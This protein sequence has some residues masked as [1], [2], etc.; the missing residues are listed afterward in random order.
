MKNNL[1]KKNNYF[2]YYFLKIIKPK[3]YIHYFFCGILFYFI[4][5][6]PINLD[7]IYIKNEKLKNYIKILLTLGII[8]STGFSV[9]KEG[10]VKIYKNTKKNKKITLNVN[11]LMIL[12][13]MGSIYLTNFNEA[14]LLII[15][16]SGANFLEEYIEN[17]N[18][19]EIKD[20]LKIMPKKAKLLKKD[21]D[22][23][24][25]DVNN[26]KI[27]D[28]VIV[29]N[30]EQIPSDGIIISGSSSIDESNI[31]G[32]S[33][34][35]DKKTGDKVF[36]SN[37]N[38]TQTLII[39]VTTTIDKTVF[40]RIIELTSEI[41]N[42]L[43]KKATFIK[44]IE[45]IYVKIILLITTIIIFSSG[46]LALLYPNFLYWEFRD[47]FYKSMVF[48]TISSPCALAV[49]DIPATLSC[50][51]NL[52]KKG[53]LLKNSQ[54]LSIF[55]E[56]KAITFDKT[57]TLTQGKMEVKNIFFNSRIPEE[58]K[59]N[60]LNIFLAMEK[61][62]NH[63]IAI[64]I[65]KYFKKKIKSQN[66][67][68][69][70][71]V[72]IIGIGIEAQD[73]QNNNYKITKHN[74][75]SEVSSEIKTK[76]EEFLNDGNTVI[77]LIH[78]NN[79]IFIIGLKDEVRP[80]AKEMIKYFKEKNI[81]TIMLTGDNQQSASSIGSYLGMNLIHSDCLPEDKVKYINELKKKY[82]NIA[83]VGDGINDSPALANSDVSIT[84]KEGS[85]VS[86]DIAD[87]VLIKNDLNKIIYVYK[88]SQKLKKIILQ[89]II[90]SLGV[91]IIF[92]IFNWFFKLP[93]NIAVIFHEGSTLLVILNCLRLKNNIQDK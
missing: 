53:V 34:P 67:I 80:E 10:F 83:M 59:M 29:L 75:F 54:S 79:V 51:S 49:V 88:I 74:H 58:K 92:S 35:V 90:L 46:M 27:G 17:K 85:D 56:I 19:K 13:A 37:I 31:T 30:G 8:F 66:H 9:I 16:F 57:G 28:K 87:I 42:K 41:Q 36:A 77:Y 44:K 76:T 23:Q 24:F 52:A 21:N 55:S 33:L 15:I 91:I 18:K 81:T 72:N 48:L 89:N 14:I 40:S 22:F 12:S 1:E 82:N 7:L 3:K 50:I 62:S 60:Y 71:T 11:I 69:L 26:L 47:I 73:N 64:S 43:S 65:Q 25:I 4:F 84:L 2:F 93:L 32:E 61:E 63:P 68:K 38:L 78:N 20:I 5:F 70:K 45:P 6:V 86:I 39:E